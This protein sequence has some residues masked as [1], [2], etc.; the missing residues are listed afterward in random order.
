MST[1]PNI[2]LAIKHALVRRTIARLTQLTVAEGLTTESSEEAAEIL[3]RTV[4]ASSGV[5]LLAMNVDDT[6]WWEDPELQTFRD[7]NVAVLEAGG[8]IMRQFML[9]RHSD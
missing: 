2:E 4:T 5:E 7:H 9:P 8:R 6:L 1:Y 3:W